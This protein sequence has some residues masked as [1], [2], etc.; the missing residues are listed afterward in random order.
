MSVSAVAMMTIGSTSLCDLLAADT[1]NGTVIVIVRRPTTPP[2]T[3]RTPEYNPFFAELMN[4]YVILGAS[5][6]F[7]TVLVCLT[8]TAGDYYSTYF[9]TSD[10]AILLPVSGI[11]GYYTLTIITP[12]GTHY[13]GEFII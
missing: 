1:N 12:D 2:E 3:P 7:G 4:D 9:D 5:S 11:A 6:A 10:G 8:S 13:V